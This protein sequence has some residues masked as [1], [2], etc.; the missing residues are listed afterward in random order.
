MTKSIV[1]VESKKFVGCGFL[2]EGGYILTAGHN[3]GEDENAV[4]FSVCDSD[5]CFEIPVKA[6]AALVLSSE[7]QGDIALY[8]LFHPQDVPDLEKR[9]LR[10]GDERTGLGKKTWVFGFCKGKDKYGL[11]YGSAKIDNLDSIHPSGFRQITLTDPGNISGGYS[12]APVVVEERV[13]GMILQRG[14]GAA[15]AAPA[16]WIKEKIAPH[17]SSPVVSK[18]PGPARP[19]SHSCPPLP[20]SYLRQPLP[21]EPYI[22]LRPFTK[23]EARIFFGRDKDIGE[24]H[25]FVTK[26]EHRVTL[27]FGQSGVGKSSLL[28][29][30][31]FP[32]LEERWEV[33]YRRRKK[34]QGLPAILEALAAENPGGVR[35]CLF[36]LDQVEEMYTN[37][38]DARPPEVEAFFDKLQ[39][40]LKARHDFH[41]ILGFR[42][43]YFAQVQDALKYHKIP[44]HEWFLKPL[45]REGVSEAIKKPAELY[46]SFSFKKRVPED[47]THAVLENEASHIAPLLQIQLKKLYRAGKK[48]DPSNIYVDE[49]LFQ[50]IWKKNLEE[51]LDEQLA[52]L[53][54]PDW[55]EKGLSL[56][57]LHVFTTEQATATS[58]SRAELKE[59]YAHIEHIDSL[60]EG[61]KDCELLCGEYDFLETT[62][63]DREQR[64]RLTHDALAPLIRK[65]YHDSDKV[66]QRAW[67]LVESKRLDSER[68]LQVGFDEYDIEVMEEGKAYMQAIPSYLNDAIEKNKRN[69]E[70]KRLALR[71]KNDFIFTTLQG[72]GH[73]NILQIEHAD[74]LEKFRAALDVDVPE[75]LKKEKIGPDLKELAWFFAETGNYAKA[76]EAL[77]IFSFFTPANELIAKGLQNCRENEWK[78]KAAFGRFFRDWDPRFFEQMKRRYYP[79]MLEVEGGR[80]TM[81]S[82]DGD[83][84]EMPH[85]VELDG[86]YLAETPLTNWQYG[87]YLASEGKDMMQNTPPWGRYGNRPLVLIP[88]Y[89]AIEYLNWLNEKQG[90]SPTYE[91]DK[92]RQDPD[93]H[94]S[95]D[96]W[97]WIVKR[98]AEVKGYT[99]PTEAQWE[100]AAGGGRHKSPFRY[101][102][103]DDIE[104]VAWYAGNA[105]KRA[106]PV[107]SKKKN[108]LGLYDMSGNVYEWC[109]D[110]YDSGYYELC[111]K[112]GLVRNPRGT[113]E[114]MQGDDG[115]RVLRGGSWASSPA[116]C[117]VGFRDGNHANFRY[118]YVCFRV[119][120][121]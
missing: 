34:E 115:G 76:R 93:N 43:E 70:A 116:R 101:S 108:E 35:P 14:E 74:A 77:E 65:R 71:E 46:A 114:S 68:G 12:G 26:G 99:L 32:R 88:W 13:L 107:A 10:L 4:K 28:F 31:L 1:R 49:N 57:L 29:G 113:A 81:G 3:I 66:A 97:K 25:R 17:L 44:F 51:L 8:K 36:I 21:E 48:E 47:I 100:Y 89:E 55:N 22:G 120:Q 121:D 117:R 82:K 69:I 2:L 50:E 45:D 9:Q 86:F 15:I 62:K 92:E 105:Q 102:G 110:W 52:L 16:S 79:T 40:L 24:V 119:A 42:S 75:Y 87:L 103:S 95:Y 90:K 5:L 106:W 91:V 20:E 80:F 67:R 38:R 83:A 41:L 94:S 18:K 78:D 109:E 11:A 58:L 72:G 96:H 104:E 60:I 118:N 33:V 39:R 61:L 7:E 98:R 53:S 23:R 73:G 54:N 64:I 85:E 19:A 112:R 63:E 111:A 37:P 27:L 56:D 30:G 6:K 84:D 59:K